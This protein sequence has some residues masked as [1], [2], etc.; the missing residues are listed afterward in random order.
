MG[1]L[2]SYAVRIKRQ[3]ALADARRKQ[4]T[5]AAEGGKL[6]IAAEKADEKLQS[7]AEVRARFSSPPVSVPLVEADTT[8]PR[9]ALQR[10]A[11]LTFRAL[12]QAS[13]TSLDLFAAVKPVKPEPGRPH[14]YVTILLEAEA[15]E[16]VRAEEKAA[17]PQTPV[18]AL[19]AA[20]ALGEGLAR[21]GTPT[22]SVSEPSKGEA[23]VL[24]EGQEPTP[25]VSPE[26]TPNATPELT[27]APE[28]P[29]VEMAE[30]APAEASAP[31]S[32][33]LLAAAVREPTPSPS[34]APETTP[35]PEEASPVPAVEDTPTS[36]ADAT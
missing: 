2:K 4:L 16:K 29:S 35:A 14:P 17:E 3:D 28:V 15:A 21:V 12:R 26:P 19:A 13:K 34:P 5:A 11:S 25:I 20:A 6:S 8:P 9:L 27:P 31:L 30:D 1:D 18:P 24:V 22:I 33:T 32:E 7:H 36:A 10:K 23:V